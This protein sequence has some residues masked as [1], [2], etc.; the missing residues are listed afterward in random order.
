MTKNK[1]M[2]FNTPPK[3]NFKLGI[4]LKNTYPSETD[5]ITSKYLNGARSTTDK[6][7]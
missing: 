5:S 6:Y 1:D 2:K 7:W 4:S 3:K